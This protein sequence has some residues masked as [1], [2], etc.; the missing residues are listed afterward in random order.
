MVTNVSCQSCGNRVSAE[1][2]RVFGNDENELY[3]CPNCSTQRATARGAGVDDDRDGTL[4]VHRP[5]ETEPVETVTETDRTESYATP[6][7]RVDDRLDSPTEDT[8]ECASE[9]DDAF[10]AL[11]AE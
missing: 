4:L 11:V 8:R 7:Y 10:D 6:V 3:A 1:Y 5:D 9:T 2:A